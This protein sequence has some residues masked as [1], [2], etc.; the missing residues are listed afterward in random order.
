MDKQYPKLQAR[1]VLIGAI[2]G[3]LLIG[4]PVAA[5]PRMP[6][7]KR[8]MTNPNPTILK[9]PTYNHSTISAQAGDPYQNPHPSI[10]SE[11]PY[12]RAGS[13]SSGDSGVQSLPD[14]GSGSSGS[15]G[16]MTAPMQ[17]PSDSQSGGPGPGSLQNPN[18][19]ASV[20]SPGERIND[21][22]SSRQPRQ[23]RLDTTPQN[24]PATVPSPSERINDPSSSTQPPAPGEAAPN[25]PSTASPA[26]PR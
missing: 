21:P 13:S 9:E 7:A 14:S 6:R 15:S 20:P 16:T 17:Q 18:P 5:K 26:T 11:P 4:L 25:A 24:P 22:S 2:C 3:S 1:L 12:T 10:F 23:Q 8:P 19:P